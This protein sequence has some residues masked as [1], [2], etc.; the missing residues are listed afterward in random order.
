MRRYV[1]I[2]SLVCSLVLGVSASS[3]IAKEKKLPDL[4]KACAKECPNATSNEEVF[5]CVENLENQA[6]GEKAFKKEH[7]SCYK[8]HEKYEK[9]AGKEEAGELDGREH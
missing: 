9:K 7:K 2:P 5:K 1:V 4:T 3:A 8:A 6:G